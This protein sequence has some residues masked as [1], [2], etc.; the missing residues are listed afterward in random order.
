[1]NIVPD[2]LDK[3]IEYLGLG[4]EFGKWLEENREVYEGLGES[5]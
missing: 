3:Y 4:E 2:I 1:M 5:G